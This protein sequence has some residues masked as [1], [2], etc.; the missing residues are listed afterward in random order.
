MP[1]TPEAVELR[2]LLDT[3]I[4]LVGADEGSLL[5]Y[6][7]AKRVLRFVLTAGSHASEQNLTGQTL[8]LGAGLTGLAAQLREVQLGA[9][10]YHRIKQIGRRGS[11]KGEP[12]AVIAAPMISGDILLGVMTAVRFGRNALFTMDDAKLIGRFAAVAGL[13]IEQDRRLKALAAR[14]RRHGP[15][16]ARPADKNERKIMAAIANIRHRK[17]RAMAQLA[18]AIG[19][20]E[21]LILGEAG[22]GDAVP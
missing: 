17:P 16:K 3:G 2:W 7:E 10:K 12:Q 8:P 13:V 15:D 4:H 5:A 22:D 14:P 6:D 1:G 11:V 21:T 9:P 19:A 20:M 18:R